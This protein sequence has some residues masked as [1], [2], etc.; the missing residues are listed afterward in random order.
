MVAD[1]QD[2]DWFASHDFLLVAWSALGRGFFA[3]GDPDDRSDADLVRVF[4]SDANFERKRRAELLAEKKRLDLFEIAL[5]YVVNQDFPLDAGRRSP[6]DESRAR[7]ARPHQQSRAGLTGRC[8][9][10]AG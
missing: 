3:K 4:Y 7:L 10:D 9:A 2:C 6:V 1:G 8:G 5:G